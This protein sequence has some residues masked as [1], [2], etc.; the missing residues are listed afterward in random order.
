MQNVPPV[1]RTTQ[2]SGAAPTMLLKPATGG[3]LCWRE[4]EGTMDEKESRLAVSK[5]S[6]LP[7]LAA[8]GWVC[9]GGVTSR[10]SQP[11]VALLSTS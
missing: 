5:Q 2:K 3:F 1:A 11:L 7:R 4:S 6:L 10:I 9:P 8:V